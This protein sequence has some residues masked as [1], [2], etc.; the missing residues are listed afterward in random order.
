MNEQHRSSIPCIQLN[1]NLLALD[2]KLLFEFVTVTSQTSL[3]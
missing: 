3:R 2:P 1:T